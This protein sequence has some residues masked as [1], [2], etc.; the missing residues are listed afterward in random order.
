MTSQV[1]EKIIFYDQLL[2]RSW[3][4]RYELLNQREENLVYIRYESDRLKFM[5][6]RLKE[7]NM[8]MRKRVKDA[9]NMLKTSEN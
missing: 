4:H 6:E 9:Q 3:I 8:V 7:I 2:S 1:K 5:Q